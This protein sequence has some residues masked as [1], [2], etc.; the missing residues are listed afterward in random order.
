MATI[1]TPDRS[2]L[3][4]KFDGYKL[5]PLDQEDVVLRFPLPHKLSQI[6]QF[7]KT[8]LSFQEMQSRIRHNHLAIGPAGNAVFISSDLQVIEFELDDVCILIIFSL[9][10]C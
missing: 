8:P 9:I 6:A 5:D 2:L 7:S 1:F 10:D 4:S 3:N